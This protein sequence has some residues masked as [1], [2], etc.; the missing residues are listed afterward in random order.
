MYDMNDDIESRTADAC[1]HTGRVAVAAIGKS[2]MP[3][4]VVIFVALLAMKLWIT[5][6]VRELPHTPP[7]E[8][9]EPV[10]FDETVSLWG[11]SEEVVVPGPS[12]YFITP[13]GIW[14]M[15]GAKAQKV[16]GD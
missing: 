10:T 7:P 13:D 1:P 9:T 14:Y 5:G 6:D 12:A 11:A 16:T 15:E 8:P 2:L 3:L 4:A